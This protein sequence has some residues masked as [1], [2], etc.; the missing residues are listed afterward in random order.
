MGAEKDG[1]QA[2]TYVPGRCGVVSLGLMG[3]SFAKAFAAAGVEVFAWNRTRSTLELAMIETVDGELDEETIPTCELIVLAGYPASAVEWLE[4]Y[5]ALVSPGAIVIDTVGVKRVI[6]ERCE[7]ICEPYPFTFVGCH[8]MAGTQ[9]S[10]FARARATM[11]KGAPMVVVPPEMDDLERATVL[12]RLKALLA[13]CE[14]GSFTLA[15]ADEHDRNIAF[16]SQLAHVVSNAYVK[17][18]TARDHRGF[19]AGSYR[20]LTRVARLNAPMWTELFLDNA[21]HLGRELDVIIESLSAYR[22]ALAAGDA[23]RLEALLAEGDRIKREI[24]GR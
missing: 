8:P 5:A 21:D 14:F 2:P 18:P 1:A 19:S 4:R 20:D 9:Y 7:K 11:F 24:E 17:S 13:P 6:C 22:D 23:E 10:G 12:E 15:T 3:G 16:T